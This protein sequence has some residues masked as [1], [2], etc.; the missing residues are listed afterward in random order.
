MAFGKFMSDDAY[1]DLCNNVLI[2][3]FELPEDPPVWEKAAD[4]LLVA[5][6]EHCSH[7]VRFYE[8]QLP[9]LVRVLR[10]FFGTNA[11]GS[12][13]RLPTYAA[14]ASLFDHL[15]DLCNGGLIASTMPLDN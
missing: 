10:L 7:P 14:F 8:S 4:V 2:W 11:D 1:R 3:I 12:A 5:L 15:V 13:K 9:N 6:Q